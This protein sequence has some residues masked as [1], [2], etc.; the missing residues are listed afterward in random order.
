[1]EATKSLPQEPV[2]FLTCFAE[3]TV[4]L[5]DQGETIV[6]PTRSS[7]S[8]SRGHKQKRRLIPLAVPTVDLSSK[9]DFPP[10]QFGSSTLSKEPLHGNKIPRNCIDNHQVHQLSAEAH[11]LASRHASALLHVWQDAATPP[12]TFF[13][14]VTALLTAARLGKSSSNVNTNPFPPPGPPLAAYVCTVLSHLAPAFSTFPTTFTTHLTP[15]ALPEGRLNQSNTHSGKKLSTLPDSSEEI[16]FKTEGMFPTGSFVPRHPRPDGRLSKLGTKNFKSEDGLDNN[17]V[18]NDPHADATPPITRLRSNLEATWDQFLVLHRQ[19]RGEIFTASKAALNQMDALR[20]MAA[21]HPANIDLFSARMLALLLRTTRA[22]IDTP[23]RLRRLDER[24]SANPFPLHVVP[25]ASPS[26]TSIIHSTRRDATP[27]SSPSTSTPQKL[28]RASLMTQA[29]TPVQA[30]GKIPCENEKRSVILHRVPETV[31]QAF[32]IEHPDATFFL[33]FLTSVD[34]AR[35]SVALAPRLSTAVLQALGA[36]ACA[37]NAEAFTD[38]VVES[39]LLARLLG[40]CLHLS[41]WPYSAHALSGGCT[42]TGDNDA[43]AGLS[44]ESCELRVP[45][46]HASATALL[47]VH[48]LIYEAAASGEILAVVAA[49]GVADAVLRAAGVDPVARRTDWFS[50]GVSAMT[51]VRVEDGNGFTLAIVRAIVGGCLQAP[52]VL[53]D[54]GLSLAVGM[55][56]VKFNVS[57]AVQIGDARFLKLICPNIEMLRKELISFSSDRSVVS[58]VARRITPLAETF[59]PKTTR[60]QESQNLSETEDDTDNNEVTI[61]HSSGSG[62]EDDEGSREDD[63]QDRLRREFFSRLDGRIREL[64]HIVAAAR[65]RGGDDD[66]KE[67]QDTFVKAVQ[68]LYPKTPL[69]ITAVASDACVRR[70]RAAN[71]RQSGDHKKDGDT[72]RYKRVGESFPTLEESLSRA[73]F[74]K[75]EVDAPEDPNHLF[76]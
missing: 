26:S 54:D 8:V 59:G 64:V 13:A 51:A 63:I 65:T 70:V 16:F 37:K 34:S 66:E 58:A 75:D 29:E 4:T 25:A 47:D 39:R 10:L 22:P 56:P 55:A 32:A 3:A 41:N 40:V 60:A 18:Y 28:N 46:M 6:T 38:A 62:D 73:N 33:D 5:V 48:A 57:S 11:Q 72:R 45:V 68:L 42:S 30:K 49:I 15:E 7:K 71:R 43:T 44:N 69:T 21:L 76:S 23:R 17:S 9:S 24:L 36:A 31:R 1:M 12:S 20:T 19:Y 2:P 67:A 27:K 50:R 52:G 53:P 35:M 74:K 14:S 61:R